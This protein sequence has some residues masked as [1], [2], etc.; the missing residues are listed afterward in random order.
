MKQQKGLSSATS[1]EINSHPVEP[2]RMA[3]S[4]EHKMVYVLPSQ[5]VLC[6][7]FYR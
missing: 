4:A 3:M 2:L 5:T 6:L 1:K 7:F